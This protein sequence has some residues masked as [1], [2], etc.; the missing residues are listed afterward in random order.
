MNEIKDERAKEFLLQAEALME[1]EKYTEVISHATAG[2]EIILKKANDFFFG[3]FYVNSKKA[4]QNSEDILNETII[5]YYLGIN[6]ER[7]IRY[8]KMAGYFSITG[9]SKGQPVPKSGMFSH[10]KFSCDKKDAELSLEYCT[11]T[12]I[13]IQKTLERLSKPLSK[14]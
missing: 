10:V 6:I 4:V 13:E 12:I 9:G 5:C 2:L 7:Y 8:R 14:E 1:Q 11:E 3:N